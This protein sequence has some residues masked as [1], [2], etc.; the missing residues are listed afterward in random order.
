M[1]DELMDNLPLSSIAVPHE[2]GWMQSHICVSWFECFLEY[3]ESFVVHVKFSRSNKV[4]L[5][6]D[7]HC[8]HVTLA[9]INYC[10]EN[11]IVM[12]GFLPHSTHRLQSL[13]VSFLDR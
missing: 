10:R 2:S 7:N 6:V 11:G 12:I 9:G 5:L 13:D 8:S 4:L 3:L 1:K